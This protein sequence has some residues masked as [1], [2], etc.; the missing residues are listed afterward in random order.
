MTKSVASAYA[1]KERRRS[2]RISQ[3]VPLTI[4]GVGSDGQPFE[5]RTATLDLS[6]H[7]CKFFARHSVQKGVWLT[8]KCPNRQTA[9]ERRR[10]RARV[11]WCQASR[12]LKGLF[13]IGAD[14]EVPGNLWGIDNPPANWVQPEPQELDRARFE[15]ELNTL[16]QMA[17]TDNYYQLLGVNAL[18]AKAEIKRKYY[19]L[20]R[21]FHPDHHTAHPERA[22]PLRKLMEVVTQAYK[23]LTDD[24][25]RQQYDK[26]LARSGAFALGQDRTEEQKSAEECL[27]TAMEC[28]R[29]KNFAGSILWL[30]QCVGVEPNSSKYHALLARSLAAVQQYRRE[31]VEHFRRAIE[32]DPW[33]L[34]AHFHLA[35]LF[36]EMQLPW[37]ALA[38][39][40]KVLEIDPGNNKAREQIRLLASAKQTNKP[41]E[42]TFLGRILSRASR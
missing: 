18:S 36:I 13:Q 37:R 4:A 25:L 15:G 20:A 11:M 26:R 6:F 9:D 23:T 1:G 27:N 35:E 33:N 7:G 2:S 41:A 22:E 16:L 24:A 8:L 19:H 40:Q 3:S 5:E 17:T 38:L 12:R 14:L 32:L 34:T 29:A 31:A 28:L 10:V 30:R 42:G 21:K 39:Y